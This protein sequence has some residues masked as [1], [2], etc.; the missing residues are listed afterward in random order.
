MIRRVALSAILLAAWTGAAQD[1]AEIE[2]DH[3]VRSEYVTPHT[4]W[5]RPYARGKTRVLFFVNGRGGRAREVVE[6]AQRFDF[7]PQMVFWG[8]I[9]DSRR[10]DWHGGQT[11]VER[12]A[13]L[14]K[15]P[16]DAFVFLDIRLSKMPVEQQYALL[17][18]VVDGAGLTLV[19]Y[20]DSRVLKPKNRLRPLPAFLQDVAGAAAFRIRNGR[21]A[22][23]PNA[24]A[25]PFRRGWLVDYD[26]W[27]MR[28]G[29]AI[30]WTAGKEP[31]L[32]LEAAARSK[33][34][35]RSSLPGPAAALRWSAAPAGVAAR[36]A[37]RRDDGAVVARAEL[38][39]KAAQGAADIPIP[40]VRAGRYVLDVVVRAQGKVVGFGSAGFE[41]VADAGVKEILLARDW[42]EIGERIEGR[43]VLSGAVSPDARVR[44]S[45]FDRR[46]RE[47][48]RRD[49]KPAGGEARFAFDAA[50]HFPMLIEARATL[51]DR[52]GEVA[53]AWRYARV[54]KRRRGRFNFVMW[55]IPRG[56]LAPLAERMLARTG[57]TVHLS[58]AKVPLY[59]AAY[60]IAWIP[61]TTHLGRACKPVCWNDD[62]RIEAY[63]NE[64]A[65]K[66]VCTRR[67]GVFVYSLGDEIKV[68]GSCTGPHCLAAYRRYLRGQYRD[69]AALNAS[70]GAH[71]ASFD[72][73]TLSRPDDND[74]RAAFKAGAFPRWFDRQAFQS[75]TFCKLCERFGR[76]FRRIDP[77]SR[78]GFEGAGRFRDADDLDG[79]V[80][81]N[82][83]W[84]PYPG[85]ADEVL[86][87]IAPRDFPRSNWMGYTKDADT[88]LEKYWRMVTRGCDA[89][90]WWR[91]EVIGRFHGWLSPILDPYPAVKELLRDT[92]V[93][94]D[95]LGDL[96]LHSQMQTDR[97]GVL[98]SLPSAY[99]ARVQASPSFGKYERDHAAFHRALREL[100]LN[101]LY[102]TD[103]Q[104]RL[105]EAN[106]ARF[107]VIILPM[108][109]AMSAREAEMFRAFVR[110]G[111]LL[112]ADVRP[113]IY[114]GHVKPLA[115]GRLDDVFGVKRTSFAAAR[116]AA[117]AIAL[118]DAGRGGTLR[119]RRVRAD[120]DVAAAGARAWG[121]AGETPLWLVN[122]F[123][124]GRAVLL[125]MPMADY[126]SLDAE[127]TDE[128]AA[129]LLETLL[130]RAGVAPALRLLDAKGRR[131]RNVEVTRWTNGPVQI[132]SVFRHK[133][134]SE[135]ATL[136]LPRPLFAYDLKRHNALGKKDA[137]ALTITPYRAQFFALS[138]TPIEPAGLRVPRTVERG[139][140]ARIRL[141]SSLPA[142]QQAVKIQVRTP[143]GRLADWI[144]SVVIVG[145]RGAAAEA[146]IAFNDPAGVWT[147][148]ATE[149]Y[150]GRT[151]R[152]EFVAR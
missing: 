146:A 149:L 21:G 83:F 91:W 151:T 79:F 98:Y 62:A 127:D 95:G 49:V 29:K 101:F 152:A 46:G 99:A 42:A 70:W 57:V 102:F 63:V 124:K 11:G 136:R 114:T 137:F 61:Y 31:T 5:A 115:A 17:K 85:P 9:I 78:C 52:T 134:Q 14:L 104:M 50:A 47:L 8:R 135:P 15:Q 71:Y 117:G 147:V 55:D 108:T 145:P 39:L 119:L 48:A 32:R 60:D 43:A 138:P 96:L 66:H 143:D 139:R 148:Q 13:R 97:I 142:G 26:E 33:R 140:V 4:K 77:K 7:E 107:K 109:Q 37:L 41:V 87:S 133:G 130:A 125:N 81:S 122:E 116:A 10:D 45:L 18:Q 141:A 59:S 22:R 132:V 44:I 16:W 12:M 30:L 90:W 51:F 110:G 150:T 24:P 100:G 89:V 2:A 74:E 34:L 88:L 6:L 120:A 54:V 72:E 92:Q 105:G 144:D 58:G 106:L 67:H 25:M 111:G 40:R 38:P 121:R 93:V 112:I 80:R 131:L 73:V 20:D 94:R 28:L 65:R 3:N 129:H 23:L 75:Y 76:A 84:T 126:P 82:T 86:R 103:R 36:I 68:R 113:A 128:A 53:S 123:G 56:H 19:G 35:K 64:I 27:A 1:M 118:P 69:I